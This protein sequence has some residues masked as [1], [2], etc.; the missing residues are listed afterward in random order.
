MPDSYR[1]YTQLVEEIPDVQMEFLSLEANLTKTI[2]PAG[3]RYSYDW[4]DLKVACSILPVEQLVPHLEKFTSYIKQLQGGQPHEPAQRLLRQ[5]QRTRL[6][7]AVEVTPEMDE[8]ATEL[9]DKLT[10]ELRPLIFS[11]GRLLDWEWKVLLAPT[12][13]G[14]ATLAAPAPAAPPPASGEPTENQQVRADR[15]RIMLDG[16]KVPRGD[17]PLYAPDDAAVRLR[18]PAEAAGRALVLYV[19][20]HCAEGASCPGAIEMLRHIELWHAVSPA[21][22]SFLESDEPDTNECLRLLWRFESIWTLLWALGHVRELEWPSAPCGVPRLDAII[23]PLATDP[24][25]IDKA[26]L[27]PTEEI[28][29]ELDL[30]L[31]LH[32]ALRALAKRGRRIPY[33]LD[34]SAVD[35]EVPAIACPGASIVAER[36]RALTWLCSPELEWD[37]VD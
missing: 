20:A 18:S 36:H 24:A 6:V 28:L 5:I 22:R 7:M 16:F 3:P 12:E 8:R 19:V 4:G 10:E 15:T 26:E 30:T 37:E 32:R 35:D 13:S 1:L 9:L 2:T 14:R 21:E 27:R 29:N 25:F 11:G 17:E 33:G 34:W 31:H 23:E